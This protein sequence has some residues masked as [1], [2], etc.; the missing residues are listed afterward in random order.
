M[1]SPHTNDISL[2]H[3]ADKGGILGLMNISF[4]EIKNVHIPNE[5]QSCTNKENSETGKR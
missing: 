2:N 4:R 1:E 5:P 3:G